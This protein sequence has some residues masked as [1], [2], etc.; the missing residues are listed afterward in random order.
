[1][2]GQDWDKHW[3]G[4][5]VKPTASKVRMIKILDKYKCK[6]VLDAGCGSGF[7][8]KYFAERGCNITAFDYSD[9]ALKSAKS[10][11]SRIKTIKGD[12]FNM[13]FKEEF[14]LV[15]SDGLLEH[16]KDPVKILKKFKDVTKP[17]GYVV[18][19]VPNLISYWIFIKPFRLSHIKEWRFGLK[20]LI[21]YNQEAGLKVIESGGFSV[22]PFKYSPEFLGKYIGRI[23]YTIAVKQ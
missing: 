19:F 8:S 16:Y 2:K 4:K 23:I 6:N 3:H 18:T 1:M 20:K 12:I 7:F 14:D 22:L 21:K 9:E 10:L 5:E 17:G 15:F 11:D 13:P